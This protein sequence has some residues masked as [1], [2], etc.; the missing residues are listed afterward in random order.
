MVAAEMNPTP[1]SDKAIFRSSSKGFTFMEISAS[2]IFIFLLI[3]SMTSR[4]ALIKNTWTGSIP[5][6]MASLSSSSFFRTL[7]EGI[8]DMI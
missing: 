5:F 2:R 1:G 8:P 3:S 6:L 4:F 7:F